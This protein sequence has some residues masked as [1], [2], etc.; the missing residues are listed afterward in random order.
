MTAAYLNRNA[1]K[2]CH[3]V[4]HVAGKP[5]TDVDEDVLEWAG[6]V[7]SSTLHNSSL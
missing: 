6:I 2:V 7:C 1:D 5:A 3:S 4:I